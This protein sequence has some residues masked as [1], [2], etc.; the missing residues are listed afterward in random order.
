MRLFV[1][2]V[3]GVGGA[4]ITVSF[5]N[6]QLPIADADGVTGVGRWWCWWRVDISKAVAAGVAAV[7]VGGVV[8]PVVI[9][10][11]IGCY[12]FHHCQQQLLIVKTTAANAFSNNSWGLSFRIYQ[13][14]LFV[15]LAVAVAAVAVV[16]AVFIVI[17]AVAVVVACY[18]CCCCCSCCFR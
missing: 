18:C 2:V 13:F 6:P 10:K 5:N 12:H 4:E 1:C 7:V 15:V 3:V 16:V 9:G 8:G 14:S 17:A 11:S